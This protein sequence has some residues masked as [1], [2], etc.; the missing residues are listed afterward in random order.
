MSVRI[1]EAFLSRLLASDKTGSEWDV[2][3]IAEGDSLNGTSYPADTLRAA[4]SMF[5]GVPVCAYQHSD[6]EVPFDH[7]TDEA[8][9]A[10]GGQSPILNAI[11]VLTQPRF[12]SYTC[13]QTGKKK[14]G[15]IARLKIGEAFARLKS[16]MKTAFESSG[17]AFGFSIDGAGDV[18]EDG[19]VSRLESVSELTLVT[20]PAAG[21]SGLRLV[22][23]LTED[24]MDLKTIIKFLQESAPELMEGRDA[25]SLTESEVLEL[26]GKLS[27][28]ASTAEMVDAPAAAAPA[29]PAAM[30]LDAFLASLTP[31]QLS[32]LA[33]KLAAMA[34]GGGDAA[35][36]A[37]APV[38]A[39][40]AESLSLL[41]AVKVKLSGV[42]LDKA[43]G[44]SKLEDISKTRVRESLAGRIL[45]A[46]EIASAVRAECEYVDRLTESGKV[47]DMG[48][49]V[50]P[51][52]NDR[53]RVAMEMSF[54]NRLTESDAT[55]AR[56]H[57]IKPF[58]SVSH[59]FESMDD[60]RRSIRTIRESTRLIEALLS[61]TW[62][63]VF[64]DC[65]HKRLLQEYGS[66]ANGYNLEDAW[67]IANK[68]P[69][70]DIRTRYVVTLGG[71]GDL[72]TVAEGAPYLEKTAFGDL[73]ETYTPTK[74]GDVAEVTEEAML[75]DDLNVITT[76]PAKLG[77][78]ARRQLY[79]FV[80]DMMDTNANF[81]QDSVAWFHTSSHG[82]NLETN[83]LSQAAIKS[84]ANLLFEM[85]EDDS[86][87]I[88]GLRPNLLLVPNE[89][90]AE[91]KSITS[92]GGQIGYNTDASP[93][94]IR[95]LESGW[96]VVNVTH[97]T[98]ANNWYCGMTKDRAETIEIGFVQGKEE[99]EI[100]VQDDPKYGAR[101][102]ADKILYKIRHWY[103]GAPVNY[104]TFIRHSVT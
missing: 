103:G 19:T 66:T 23:S 21:G 80:F 54:G 97:W 34:Q 1:N 5:E 30:D 9:A 49:E 75:Q 81:A 31:E 87:A 50:G 11:G 22:A 36:P 60:Q 61:S 104:R 89:L 15:I 62:T 10:A 100:W 25:A 18:E 90:E 95:E 45:S 56:S 99:P 58:R 64:R 20:R 78:A 55:L 43:L 39:S 48:V 2:V 57:G 47:K 37:E 101:F 26:L 72:D 71:Y 46:D 24:A 16:W 29:A 52:R 42:D 69:L 83:A 82:G 8:R 84:D 76:I 51:E 3:V 7:M 86:S 12:E 32:E 33:E 67:L 59:M 68:V 93:S 94:H 28:V 85:T 73:A 14:N 91:A 13:P 70:E 102:S 74:Y 79:K 44:E 98:D 35:A 27:K 17:N 41:E 88:L 38:A 96:K 4:V 6:P 65:Q 63:D 92:A 77:V 40:V 53:T